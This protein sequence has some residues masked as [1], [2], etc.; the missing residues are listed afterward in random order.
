MSSQPLI[1]EVTRKLSYIIDFD[2]DSIGRRSALGDA[3]FEESIPKA[4]Q[5]KDLFER[6]S[7]RSLNSLSDS[8][9]TTISNNA[10]AFTDLIGRFHSYNPTTSSPND[11]SQLIQEILQRTEEFQNNLSATVSFS[12]SS[13]IN[14]D[15]IRKSI[16]ELVSSYQSS[17]E[18]RSQ[19]IDSMSQKSKDILERVQSAAA[20]QGI[21]RE[22]K[23][24]SDLS[25]EYNRESEKWF[26]RS[27]KLG[28]FAIFLATVSLF[29]HRIPWFAANNVSEAIQIISGKV[30]M[31]S[32]IGYALIT[33]VR[34]FI[35]NRHNAV[36]NRHKQNALMTY[37]SFLDASPSP[38]MVS[39]VLNHASSS[40]FSPQDTGFVKG[41]ELPGGKS[42]MEWITRSSIGEK[43]PN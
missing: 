22:S 35:A 10:S 33:C 32:I 29:S 40:I 38:E 34:N 36:V 25:E 19:E 13:S 41:E 20:D 43:A 1:D 39:I 24:F 14:I 3:N 37:R 8:M 27:I 26:S 30:I 31:I 18:I 28:I 15:D 2:P 4:R 5:I 21:S 12:I 7:V 17:F 42:I 6:I 23:H 11:R 9:L 16:E